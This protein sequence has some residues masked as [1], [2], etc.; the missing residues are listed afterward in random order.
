MSA[1]Y[2]DEVDALTLEECVSHPKWGVNGEQDWTLVGTMP[3]RCAA[4][5]SFTCMK[6][7]SGPGSEFLS[8]V[9]ANAGSAV[10]AARAALKT[11]LPERPP[12]V[13]VIGDDR[14]L[15]GAIWEAAAAR[16]PRDGF[17]KFPF[18]D[19]AQELIAA[20]RVKH[21]GGAKESNGQ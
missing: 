19:I 7:R 15:A 9:V 8:V 6:S 13:V 12:K 14:C 11:L 18:C 2:Q 10:E 3:N 4:V 20:Y 5:H 1:E 21:S 16:R 17:D